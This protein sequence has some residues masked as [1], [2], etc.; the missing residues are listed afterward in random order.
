MLPYPNIDPVILQLGPLEFR[1]YGLVYFLSFL[2]VY[3]WISSYT[4]WL[5]LRKKEHAES[6]LMILVIGMLLGARFIYVFFYNFDSYMHG[7]WW[8]VFAVWHGGLS[9]HGA[10][11]GVILAAYYIAKSFQISLLRLLDL[12]LVPIPLG[13][14]FGRI[15]NFIN[16]ELWGR[17]SDLPWAMVF[18]N[19]GPEPRHPSQ[20]YESFLE[21]FLL[22]AV[23]RVVWARKPRLG[24]ITSIFALCYGLARVF[25]EQF[26]E[27][28]RQ[29]G[30][31]AGSLT[32]GQL[33]SFILI[34]GGVLALY[35]SLTRKQSTQEIE[36]LAMRKSSPTPL[37]FGAERKSRKKQK[38]KRKNK[39]HKKKK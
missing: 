8:E 25:V 7:P 33:L 9:F 2:Y 18:P 23:L 12:I 17:Q 27:P 34:G 35:I 13:L 30:F 5:G 19:A 20:L 10:A 11:L 26:R 29:L 24:L 15:A 39:K 38:K 3:R 36:E 31:I 28:D 16:G 6:I 1:W 37:F 4:K 32:M 22:F 21:G 14:A